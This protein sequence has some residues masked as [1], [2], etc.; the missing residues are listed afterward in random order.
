M[1]IE[2]WLD[3]VNHYKAVGQVTNGKMTGATIDDRNGTTVD[4]NRTFESKDE[5]LAW[6][7]AK[8]GR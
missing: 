7:R 1:A 6:A 8:S 3:P 2:G 4:R 5:F